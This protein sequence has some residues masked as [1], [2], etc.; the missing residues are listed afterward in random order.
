M[1]EQGRRAREARRG[2]WGARHR[3]R[4]R[5][6]NPSKGERNWGRG[7]ARGEREAL[8]PGAGGGAGEQKRGAGRSAP[9]EPLGE[10]RGVALLHRAWQRKLGD[11]GVEDAETRGMHYFYPATAEK[12]SIGRRDFLRHR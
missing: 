2:R 4:G 1:A 10:R 5:H 7:R 11:G 3:A 8:G 9:W 6:W 12:K